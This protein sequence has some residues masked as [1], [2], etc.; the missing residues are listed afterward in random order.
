[1]P[2]NQSKVIVERNDAQ[3]ALISG[4]LAPP[5]FPGK[6]PPCPVVALLANDFPRLIL[7]AHNELTVERRCRMRIQSA[8]RHRTRV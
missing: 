6:P 1:M 3:R 4:D 7:R 8:L 5:L 2:Q